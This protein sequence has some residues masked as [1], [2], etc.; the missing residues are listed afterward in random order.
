MKNWKRF[1][2][3]ASLAT[4]LAF[5]SAASVFAAEGGTITTSGTGIVTV[6]P[7]LAQISLSVQTYGKTS[8]AAKKENNKIS[9]KVISKLEEMGVAKDKIITNYSYVYPTYSYNEKTGEN[10]I[11]RYQ[12]NTDF[13]VTIKDIDNA[14]TYIDAA[15]KAGATG[16][17]NV[18]FSL[19]D[20]TRYYTQALQLAVK[21]ASASANAIAAA[22]GKPLGQIQN[23]VE[24]SSYQS[25]EET[26]N[27]R[28][29]AMMDSTAYGSGDSDTVI[30]YNKVQVTASVTA[31]YGL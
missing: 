7:D 14:G 25:Y 17:S 5:G 2:I 6:Q 13:Q 3:T 31:T 15:L 24:Q 18:V 23:V 30:Q 26:S 28:E 27:Y 21:N 19:E 9:A 1:L 20:S 12:A 4:V 11:E 29:K 8:D 10:Y 16:F 22:Y